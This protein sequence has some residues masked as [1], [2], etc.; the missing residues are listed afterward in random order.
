[1][2]GKVG[3]TWIDMTILVVY[4]AAVLFVGLAFS[5]KEMNSLKGMEPS[6]GGLLPYQFLQLCLAQFHFCPWR[7]TLMEAH[8]YFGLHSLVCWLQSL[9][10]SASS[11]RFTAGWALIPRI[12]IWKTVSTAKVCAFWGRLCLSSIKLAACPSLCICHLWF[13]QNSPIFLSPF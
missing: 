12:S 4:L 5:K 11:C 9:S 2:N 7:E 6:P 10:P 1:M 13:L 8:G 3:F